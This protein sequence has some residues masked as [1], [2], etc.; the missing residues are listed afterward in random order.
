LTGDPT[1]SGAT[2]VLLSPEVSLVTLFKGGSL[3]SK[4][5]G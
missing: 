2:F 3:L 5:D 4:L 1:V